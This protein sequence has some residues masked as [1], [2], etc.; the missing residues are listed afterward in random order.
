MVLIAFEKRASENIHEKPL[1][2]TTGTTLGVGLRPLRSDGSNRLPGPLSRRASSMAN[3]VDGSVEDLQR[4]LETTILRVI[5]L[6]RQVSQLE[7][8]VNGN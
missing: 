7:K 5:E 3:S 4:K 2:P 1:A 8:K 6:E